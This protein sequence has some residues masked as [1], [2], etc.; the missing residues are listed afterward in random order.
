MHHPTYRIIHTTAVITPV[1]EHLLE[2]E[3]AQ[4]VHHEGSTRRPIAPM[5]ERSYHGATSRSCTT[6]KTSEKFNQGHFVASSSEFN[7]PTDGIHAH[8]N[9]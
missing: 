3:I 4:W 1:V 5:S 8:I 7:L 6:I 9:Q 2:R